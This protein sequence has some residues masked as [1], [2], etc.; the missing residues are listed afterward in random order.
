MTP[1]V[2]VL[3]APRLAAK[4]MPDSS[5]IVDGAVVPTTNFGVPL[6]STSPFWVTMTAIPHVFPTLSPWFIIPSKTKGDNKFYCQIT[7]AHCFYF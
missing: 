2:F 4:A 3:A 7:V 5:D 6:G 1:L